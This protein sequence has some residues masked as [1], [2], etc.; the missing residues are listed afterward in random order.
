V[1]NRIFSFVIGIAI[2]LGLALSAHIYLRYEKYKK[3]STTQSSW[4]DAIE[5]LDLRFSDFK[6]K[7]TPRVPHAETVLV[8]VD[9]DSIREVGRWPWSRDLMAQLLQKLADYKV[10]AVGLDVIWSEPER[11]FPEDDKKLAGTVEANADKLVLGAFS[12]NE[13]R[14]APYQDYCVNEA[15]LFNGGSDLVK[16]N[17]SLVIDDEED[18]FGGLRWD[19]FFKPIFALLV[20]N[21]QRRYLETSGKTDISQLSSFQKNALAAKRSV[22]V[23]NYCQRWL[24]NDD[25]FLRDDPDSIKTGLKTLWSEDKNLAG[26]PIDQQIDE[27]K[28]SVLEFPVPQYDGWQ[29]NIPEIQ[30]PA[31]Y[32][33]SFVA[34]LD[35]D[36][37]VRRYPLFY[38]AGNRLGTSFIPSLALQ[39]YLL[40]K[41]YRAEV[42]VKKV[43]GQK[44]IASFRILDP[45]T[46]PEQTVA[47]L[48]VDAQ[49]RLL[50]NFYGPANTLPRV[51]AKDLLSDGDDVTVW[52][53]RGFDE[54]GSSRFAPEKK[55]KTSFFK[56]RAAIVGVTSIAVY[57]L[58]NTPVAA[59]FPGTEIHLTMLANLLEG[60]FLKKPPQEEIVLPVVMVGLG[61][62]LTVVLSLMG[63]FS[64]IVCMSVV[65]IAV[66]FVDRFVFENMHFLVS[67]L[68]VY[69]EVLTLHFALLV[70]K[71]F[72]EEKKRGELKRTFSKYVSPAVVDELLRNEE[73]L[74]LG[75]RKEEMSVFFSDVR[76]FTQFSEKMDPQD[77]S[78]FLNEYLTPMTEIIFRNKG[79]LDK[80]MGD[81]VMAFF[82]APVPFKDHAAH[83]CRCA[84]ESIAAL[85]KIQEDFDKRQWPKIDIGIGIN[86]G[87]MSVGNMGSKIVQSYTV[88][89]DAVNLGSRLEGATKEYGARILVSETTY[90]AVKNDFILREVDRVRVKGKKEPVRA[91]QLLDVVGGSTPREWVSRYESAY[92]LYHA[93]DFAAALAA[94]SQL[95]TAYPDDTLSKI[96]K[97]RCEE[98]IAQPP[99][100]DWDGVFE[101]RTK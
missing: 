87:F 83:A 47:D 28:A 57:D 18:E 58:R 76:G 39:T 89:G 73:N 82:G 86:T 67:S 15:F 5:S 90:E 70:Y 81:G 40:A 4:V 26:L 100:P 24:T 65:F 41:G 6:Y 37:F 95:E 32:T 3:S 51:S 61:F 31:K 1:K 29:G 75:G 9:D 35:L 49:G 11:G 93:R 46:N 88:I 12:S 71:Y 10:G 2:T 44:T 30:A 38:R 101:M 63:A 56:N 94:F 13:I 99:P 69:V 27:F 62:L 48:P 55:S 68:F 91:Y 64:T 25:E 98:F 50:V 42:G 80:Y 53:F 78:H 54:R 8:A 66:F 59:N 17:P 84:L 36:G 92:K 7:T 21:S 52:Y 14:L 79:T 45:S 20:K 77:L 43:N 96:Y 16:L 97:E 85:K 33:G 19:E 72:S 74:K 34:F 23:Y 22:D 60:Q